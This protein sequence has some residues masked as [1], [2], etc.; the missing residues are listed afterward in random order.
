MVIRTLLFLLYVLP[1]SETEH[2]FVHEEEQE[3]LREGE[4]LFA[5]YHT[6]QKKYVGTTT[7]LQPSH[8]LDIAEGQN[9]LLFWALNMKSLP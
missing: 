3:D 7:A 2:P 6:R 4:G 1:E 5:A 9:T 8:Y